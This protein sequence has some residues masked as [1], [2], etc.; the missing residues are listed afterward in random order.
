MDISPPVP[1]FALTPT[2]LRDKREVAPAPVDVARLSASQIEAEID[3]TL[4]RRFNGGDEAAFVEIVTRYRGKI[5]AIAAQFLRNHADAQEIAQDTFVR[6]HRGLAQFRGDSSLAT[7]LHHIACNLA[8]NRYWYFFRR[9]RHLT[10]SLE[11]PLHAEAPGTL[12]ELVAS[13]DANPA[14]QATVD[15]FVVRVTACMAKLRAGPRE[16]LTLRNL[17]HRSY[18]EISR[19]LGISEGTVKSR[20][21]RARGQLRELLAESC[22]DFPAD[23]PTSEWFEP[24]RNAA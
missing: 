2:V 9:S 6:A 8:R 1:G 7:W 15:E 19:T 24:A 20:I 12:S 22:P 14:R 17:L 18:S 3:R 11:A 21:A 23:A 16:I 4:V 10:Q 5:E 13:P